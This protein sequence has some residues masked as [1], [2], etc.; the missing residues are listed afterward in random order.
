MVARPYQ[1]ID[2]ACRAYP[3]GKLPVPVLDFLLRRYTTKTKGLIVGPQIGLDATIIKWD[4]T[5]LVAKT[6]PITFTSIELGEYLVRINANDI[7][8]MG[9]QPKYL[10]VTFLLPEHGVDKKYVE[11]L[12]S[13]VSRACRSSGISFCGGHTEITGGLSR[14]IAIG[15]ML[16]EIKDS[17]R[18]YLAPAR[19]GDEIIL[20]KGIAIEGTA[21]LAGE[22]RKVL[23]KKFGNS[24]IKRASLY[25]KAPGISVLKEAEIAW[26]SGGVKAMHDPTEAGL[27]GG[28]YELSLRLK[29]GMEIAREAICILPECEEL[30]S[31]FGLN[32]LGLISSGA[33]LVVVAKGKGNKLVAAYRRKGILAAIIGQLTKK[34]KGVWLKDKKG[35]RPF[36]YFK[37]D[38]IA[39]I[40]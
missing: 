40:I 35:W 16:G 33:L 13:Q 1:F 3:V 19:E 28:L 37:R 32:P 5:F 10:L 38:E 4:K 36:P 26:Q 31:Y 8:C 7:A 11:K 12:F 29:I 20:V 30:S 24:F 17:G 34:R 6:D 15:A 21:I 18:V 14:P 22:K 39:R 9:G 25:L 23:R 2:M 27:S